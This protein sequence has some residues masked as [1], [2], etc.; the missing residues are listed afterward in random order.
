MLLK[1]VKVLTNVTKDKETAPPMGILFPQGYLNISF[2]WERK[3][4][5][6]KLG[7]NLLLRCFLGEVVY[8]ALADYVRF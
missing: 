6:S 4:T 1:A 2:T 5:N 8:K 3:S 7:L